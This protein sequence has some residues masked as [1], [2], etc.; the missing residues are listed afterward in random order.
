M[1][2]ILDRLFLSSV[3]YSRDASFIKKHNIKYILIAAKNL[4]RHLNNIVTYKQLNITDNPGTLI[5]NHFV[6]SIDFIENARGILIGLILIAKSSIL[7]HCLGGI[8]RSVTIVI[9][10]VMLDQHLSANDATKFVKDRH[11]FAYPNPG[12]LK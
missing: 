3:V 2:L 9:S 10:Y 7:V 8:S 1:S 6:E 12:F 11:K 4:K 5:I